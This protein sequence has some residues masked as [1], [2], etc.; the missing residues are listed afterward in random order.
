MLPLICYCQYTHVSDRH[1]YN[2]VRKRSQQVKA[3][4]NAQAVSMNIEASLQTPTVKALL[5]NFNFSEPIDEVLIDRQA[6]WIDFSL[7]PRLHNARACYT[8]Y[9]DPHRFESLGDIYLI[10]AG[11]AFHARGDQGGHKAMI[12]LLPVGPEGCW[13]ENK[14]DWTDRHLETSLNIR[15]GHI[16]SLL[17]RLGEEAQH[18]GF[19][20]EALAELI[21]GQ[22]TIELTR[23]YASTL[24]DAKNGVLTPWRL[25][26][27]DERLMDLTEAPTL[28]ELSE[29][30]KLSVRQ[31]TRAFRASRGCSIGDYIAQCR[32]EKAKKY[33]E[34]TQCIKEVS[35]VVGFSTPAAFSYAFRRATGETP[36][37]YR[38]R[39]RSFNFSSV[40]P[41]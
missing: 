13:F 27:I 24:D 40:R 28:T 25:R 37:E 15:N 29:L 38:Q 9:W 6:H 39:V 12:C 36:G 41:V 26:L 11:H 10:P 33:L 32:I 19:A 7:T 14:V 22:L 35:Y 31:L 4:V 34:G 1:I 17:L 8:D 20:S 18:P 16:R 21:A 5:I 23:H 2:A 3:M 30:C